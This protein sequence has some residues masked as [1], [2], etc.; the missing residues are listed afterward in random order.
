M[1]GGLIYLPR[2]KSKP[3]LIEQATDRF[4][5]LI[6]EIDKLSDAQMAESG[7]AG[8]WSVKDVLAHLTAWHEMCLSWYRAGVAGETPKT[9]SEKY[10][11]KQTPDLNQDIWENAKDL[12]LKD[13]RRRFSDSHAETLATISDISN[14]DLFVNRPFKWTKSTT[15]GSYF[16]SCTGSH[17]DWARKEI[18]KGLKQKA[19]G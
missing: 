13:V 14:E 18:R 12:P 16:V 3:E 10:T 8:D 1:S 11:W 9:P 15:L 17:Y 4:D 2:P 5:A 7:T 19:A 6:A